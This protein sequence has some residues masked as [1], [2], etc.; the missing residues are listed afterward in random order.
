[1]RRS[2]AALLLAT[3]AVFGPGPAARSD[4]PAGPPS[5]N[6]AGPLDALSLVTAA[7]SRQAS[8][9]NPT[10]EP[11]RGATATEG[12]GKGPATE[13]GVGWKVSPSIV[14]QPHATAVLADVAGSGSITHFWIT[15]SG[16][17][18]AAMLR[19]YWDGASDPS[20]SSPIGMFF[21]SGLGQPCTINSL[22]VCVTPK[23][24]CN[25]YWR[26]P[27]RRSARL[28][29]ENVSAKPVT[30]YY[31]V[32]Y[33]LAD[34]PPAAAYFCAQCRRADPVGPGGVYTILDGVR[35]RGQYVGTYLTWETRSGG[36]W[37][38]GE[39]K[40]FIDGD[41]R[42]TPTICGTGTEDY[43]GGSYDFED[44]TGHRYQTFSTPYAGL[45][46]VIPPEVI[47]KAGQRFGMYRWHLAD[48]VR[49]DRD[50][51]VTIQALGWSAV[52]HRYRVRGDDAAASV[53]YWYQD[54]P[55][56]SPTTRPATR[57]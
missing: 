37:G 11:G 1:M 13:L 36:W 40:F 5:A 26:M 35:G 51:R 31:Q 52:P 53:A 24:S 34:V 39:V 57:P 19:A 30:L 4:P 3:V 46:Q 12:T 33:E 10:G 55:V 18:Q 2:A 8:P 16:E 9:E 25:C 42:D 54:R 49:F 56:V 17:W 28:T 43:F 14:V 21:A 50:L 45:A 20:I 27:F 22:A 47:Y 48:P 44:P 15:G 32:D 23:V 7:K 38:E 6:S 41:G 29:C